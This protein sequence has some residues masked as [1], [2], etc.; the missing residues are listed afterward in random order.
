MS[1]VGRR[2]F[3]AGLTAVPFLVRVSPKLQ[4]PFLKKK[5]SWPKSGTKSDQYS[6]YTDKGKEIKTKEN[7]YFADRSVTIIAAFK[8]DGTGQILSPIYLQS[9]DSLSVTFDEKLG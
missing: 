7:P 8:S 2:G 5:Q 6:L 4:I 1:K 9:G 3:L